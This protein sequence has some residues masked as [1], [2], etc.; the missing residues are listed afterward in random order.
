MECTTFH[1]ELYHGHLP[2]QL[3]MAHRI[4]VGEGARS[5]KPGKIILNYPLQNELGGI[6]LFSTP[7]DYVKLLASLIDGNDNLLSRRSTDLL[8]APR[9]NDASRAAMP[10]QFGFQMRRILGIKDAQDIG[11]ADHSCGNSYAARYSWQKAPWHC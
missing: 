7:E 8:F 6:G 3:E 4:C 1:P 11:Q 2:Q 9:L 5:V 10:K